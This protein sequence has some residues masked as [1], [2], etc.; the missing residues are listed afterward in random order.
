MIITIGDLHLSNSRPWSMAVSNSIIDW[1]LDSNDNTKENTLVLLGDITDKASVDG[2]VT[3]AVRRLFVGLKYSNTYICVGNH[4]GEIRNGKL[5]LTYEFLLNLKLTT[6]V[7]VFTSMG[8]EVIDNV[9]CL[10]LPHVYPDGTKSLQDYNKYPDDKEYDVIFG[11]FTDS[12][13]PFPSIDKVD[14]SHLKSK[15]RI[16]GHIHSGEYK[17]IGYIGSVIPNSVAENDFPRYIAKI[18]KIGSDLQCNY[19]ELPRDFLEYKE[20]TYPDIL[21][22]TKAKVVVWTVNNA[23][24]M[25]L[26]KIHYSKPNM[27]IRKC[28]YSSTIDTKAFEQVTSAEVTGGLNFF[29]NDWILEK[30]SQLSQKLRDK[31][32]YYSTAS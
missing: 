14:V 19:E 29:L 20:V 6:N 15:L 24:D 30:G 5:S 16:Y 28:N 7:K 13:C 2:S 18:N 9:S 27:F 10:F 8:P 21:P 3:E 1:I 32:I 4:E 26:I 25:D 23:Q 31:I 17:D 22:R 11:H 12:R